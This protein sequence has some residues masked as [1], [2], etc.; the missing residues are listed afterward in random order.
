MQDWDPWEVK[1][2][3]DMK[4]WLRRAHRFRRF[5]KQVTSTLI[6]NWLQEDLPEMKSLIINMPNNTGV[7]WLNRHI[8]E[9]RDKIWPPSEDEPEEDRVAVVQT[10]S[11]RLV[12]SEDK[13]PK[14][15]PDVD[16]A[17][18]TTHTL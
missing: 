18:S 2:D 4:R 15:D 12:K 17:S 10:P 9:L 14:K 13:G 5:K 8:D 6:L 3:K 1:D 7:D 11:V 16:P